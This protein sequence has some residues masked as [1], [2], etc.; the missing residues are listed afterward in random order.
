MQ[1]EWISKEHFVYISEDCRLGEDALQLASFASVTQKDTVCDLGTGAGILPV[2]FCA[3][4]APKHIYGVEKNKESLEM[5]RKTVEENKLSNRIT[6]LEEDWNACSLLA[7]SMDVVTC[8]PPY[9]KEGSGKVSQNKTKELAR[10]TTKEGLKDV[11]KAASRLLKNGGSFYVCYKPE[12]L[13]DL[14]SALRENNLEPKE[15][16]VLTHDKKVPWLLLVKAK[17]GGKPTVTLTVE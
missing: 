16:K 11:C 17:K 6:F 14:L 7:G 2:L 8:N 12:Q 9:F 10:H 15:I 1:K 5:A 13:V 4:K 3:E